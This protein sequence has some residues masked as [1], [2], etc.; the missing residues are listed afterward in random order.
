MKKLICLLL[1]FVLVLGLLPSA[2]AAE[3]PFR[4]VSSNSWY[5]GAVEY[6]YTNGLMNG[7]GE[8]VFS[9]DTNMS[10]GMIVTVLHR[11][12]GSPASSAKIPFGDVSAKQYYYNAVV[13][14]Y[15]NGIVN[16]TSA[17]TFSPDNNVTREQLVTIF[18]RYANAKGYDAAKR[19]ELSGY[20]D[21]EKISGYA[22]EALQWAVAEGI[23]TGMDAKTL[24]PG[25]FATRAQ[26]ATIIQR[27]ISWTEAQTEEPEPTETAPQPTEEETK[28]TEEEPK[29]TETE[30]QPT[31][32]EPMSPATVLS[33]EKDKELRGNLQTAIDN[34]LYAE[35]EIVHSDTF[36]PGETYTGTAYY[37]SSDGDDSNDGLTPE[38]A[39]RSVDK[40]LEVLNWGNVLKSGDAVFLRRGDTFRLPEW[41][42]DIGV[43]GVTISAYGEGEK[44]ILTASSESGLGDEKWKLVYE[45]AS[46]K[47]IWQFYRDIRDTSMVVL[48]DGQ[49]IAKRVYEFYGD[50]GYVSCVE[51]G[52][53][54]H[55]ENGVILLDKLLSVEDSLTEDLTFISRPERY[56]AD[57][58]Y[59]DAGTGPL[60][61]RC[62][63]GN[64]GLIFRSVEFTELQPWAVVCVRASHVVLDNISLR[65][66]ANSFIKAH[67]G[68]EEYHWSDIT[69]TM[70]QNCEFTY[71]GGGVY[72]YESRSD[73]NHIIV[74][75]GDGIYT[76]VKNT[77]I[78]NNYF[79][80][81]MASTATYEWALDDE[82]TSGGYYHVLDNV[83]VNTH[84]ISLDSTGISLKYLD[85]VII[86]GNQIWNTG[87]WDKGKIMYSGGS[88][89]IVDNYYGECIV[90]DNVFYG[91]QNGHESNALLHITIYSPLGMDSTIPVIRNNTYVQYSGRK[92][93]YFP[94]WWDN[95]EDQSTKNLYIDDPYLKTKVA[96][97]TGD[98]TSEFYVTQY[99]EE[100]RELEFLDPAPETPATVLNQEKDEEL[101]ENLQTA[102]DNILY[103]ETEIVHSDTF[104]PGKTYTGT[105]Y[106]FSNEGDDS[107]DGL[108]P[109]TAWQSV[110]KMLEVLSWGNVLKPGDAIFLRRGDTF[111]LPDWALTVSVDGI[112]MSAYGE[113]DKPILTA[114]SENGTGGDKWELVCQ[115]G[116][117][118]KIWKFHNNLRDTGM[119]I[120]N[121]GEAIAERVYEFYDGSQYI[122]CEEAGW[123]MHEDEGVTLL[124]KLLPL[125]ES[126]TEDLTFISRADENEG[127]YRGRLYLRCDQGNPGEVYDSIE[128]TELEGCGIIWLEA[129]DCVFDNISMRCNGSAYIKSNIDD[130]RIHWSE[131]ENTLIQNCEFAYGGGSVW[132]Y[133]IRG[134]GN[135]AIVSQ[136]DGIYNII[137]NTTIR[138]NYFHDSLTS[139]ATFEW[140]WDDE[141][142]SGGY[143]HVLDNVIVNT[144]G[145]SFNSEPKA[146]H[147]L[148][149]LIVRGNQIWNTGRWDNGKIL[150]S[151]GS[152]SMVNNQ[153]GEYIVEDNVFYGT[154][155]SH[156]SN[157][158]LHV[159]IYTPDGTDSTVPVLRNNIYVQYSGRK[160]GYFPMWW[161][162]SSEQYDMGLYM[163]DPYLLTKVEEITG[164]TTSAFYITE[165]NAEDMEPEPAPQTPATVLSEEKDKEL[166]E[167]L[168]TAIDNILYAETEIVCSD[169][170]IPGKTYTGTAY[171]VSNDG[172]DSNDGLTPETAW[173]S[174]GKLLGVLGGWDNDVTLQPGDAVFLRRG[175][176]FR[177]TDW[178]LSVP[179]D[180]ITFS[181]YGEGE[182]PILT[183]SSENGTGGEK[184]ELVYS[185]ESGK[186]IWKYYRDMKD[187]S[188]AVFDDGEALTK[189]VYEFYDGT[190]Y[191]SCEATGWW[192][193][194]D[195]GVTLLG[196]LLPLEESMTEDL[197]IIS[198]PERTSAENQYSDCGYGPL[199]LRCD[200]GNPGELYSS[201]EF[202]EYI[203]TGIVWLEASDTVWD[204]V[205]FRCNGNSFVKA[206]TRSNQEDYIHWSEYENT[207]FQN[208]E[209][210]YGGG[211]VTSYHISPSGKVTVEAQGDGIYTVV[212]NTTIRNNYFHDMLSSTATFEWCEDDTYSDGYYYLLDNVMVNTNG[213]RLDSGAITL[214][215]LDSIIIR[216]NQVW[217]NGKLDNGKIIY[218]EASLALLG[219]HYGEC[220]VENNVFYGTEIG[221]EN[222]AL[223]YIDRYTQI[224]GL[225]DPACT[226]PIIRNNIYVQY[227]GRKLAY[228]PMWQD[229]SLEQGGT[230]LYMEDPYL[231]TR[232]AEVT[233]DTTSEFYVIESSENKGE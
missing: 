2:Y 40:L 132:Q 185:D 146:V 85:S 11:L 223:F 222:N 46:G 4:D 179:V 34:I 30:P 20:A 204:N 163:D 187:V 86:R 188:M 21:A 190:Q 198:R 130:N 148:D 29:P 174:M 39:W 98:T 160:F 176:V 135:Y 189:R 138:N 50:N 186:K 230:N 202:S 171:Y 203:V 69:D 14:S 168:Q 159:T 122:S 57:S 218:A 44:P 1:S 161:E 211:C 79:H 196:G 18:F 16:G 208:C 142:T 47:K 150:Y 17:N 227:S 73:G 120:L 213:I 170:F 192:M 139:T 149:S 156:E 76:V 81:N 229:Y 70:I 72:E 127:D 102:I 103:A 144:L 155:L 191:L 99:K 51:D 35:T 93:G 162:N 89:S 221:H 212:K 56:G 113:G 59:N 91:T 158:L 119:V 209:F 184:W 90:E 224:E 13:W 87:Y 145:M 115:D 219:D 84:G 22:K 12:E 25:G 61:L 37:F 32:T 38:T 62:D 19:I 112:T 231:R 126:L 169:T 94:M 31:E 152:L 225:R 181:A 65:G 109:E 195:E 193:H 220:I 60:Y 121:D 33:E 116:N 64:P 182:K 96:E 165:Y 131:Y 63:K 226:D 172:D 164:D 207:V 125:E 77:T 82:R 167:N 53:W 136:G 206:D 66:N 228:F 129:S 201:I 68:S 41:A 9:P 97:I 110:G 48:N 45:D 27:F 151:G 233:G 52:W 141:R 83:M 88:L 114:S 177:L 74:A 42:L 178:S 26:F 6:V 183:C 28:P 197:T 205:S 216:G 143:Y 118:T 78:R 43:E 58:N 105:A 80:D 124:D 10:R 7:T 111:R 153:Y 107:N 106:Y 128:F 214:Q 200:E 166:R 123:W 23:I 67:T 36:I 104:I 232:M 134:N 15:E 75:Q 117:G 175:D 92:L 147:Y 100:D 210:A 24:A 173:Q 8:G 71:G 215:Y 154:E 137:K 5:R 217:N 194:E 95:V 3:L 101:R 55:D 108:T 133:E 54:M 199:Y 157:A 49:G 180:Q 140:S